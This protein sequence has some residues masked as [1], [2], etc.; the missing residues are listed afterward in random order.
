MSYPTR[1]DTI[2]H[3]QDRKDWIEVA[4]RIMTKGGNKPDA[5][6]KIADAGSARIEV[7][8]S[9]QP[10]GQQRSLWNILL[11]IINSM[12]QKKIV[13]PTV[14]EMTQLFEE[15]NPPK[16]SPALEEFR[17]SHPSTETVSIPR[18][19]M[20]ELPVVSHTSRRVGGV[21]T[22]DATQGAPEAAYFLYLTAKQQQVF[23][24]FYGYK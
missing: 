8:K 21:L 20:I 5:I 12:K 7:I 16:P 19:T 22:A 4:R 23:L 17:L 3:A 14:P 11:G 2:A 1:S 18:K 10:R 15:L 13:M 24:L 9:F 6:Q